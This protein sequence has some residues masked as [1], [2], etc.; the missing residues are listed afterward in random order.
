M[1]VLSTHKKSTLLNAIANKNFII[2][3]GLSTKLI[4]KMVLPTA[5]AKGHLDQERKNLQS[6]KVSETPEISSIDSN[7]IAKTKNIICTLAP[8][9]PNKKHSPT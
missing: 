5:T 7:K 3:P 2:W 4:R 1:C 9:L 8:F 6:T